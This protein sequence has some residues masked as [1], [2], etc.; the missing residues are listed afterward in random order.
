MKVKWIVTPIVALVIALAMILTFSGQGNALM[1]KMSLNDLTDGADTVVVATVLSTESRW[2]SNN[3]AVYTLVTVEVEENYKGETRGTINVIIPGGTVGDNLEWVSDTPDLKTGDRSVLFLNELTDEQL[4]EKK[5]GI[6]SP[7]YEVFGWYQGKLDIVNDTA[8]GVQLNTL[9]G[10]VGQIASGGSNVSTPKLVS[11]NPKELLL[12]GYNTGGGNKWPASKMPVPYYVAQLPGLDVSRSFT[13]AEITALNN[14][15]S[16]WTNAGANFSML[17]KGTKNS[18]PPKFTDMDWGD[19]PYGQ[20]RNGVNENFWYNM[21]NTVTLGQA[22]FWASGLTE[23][24]PIVECDTAFNSYHTFTTGDSGVVNDMWSVALHEFGH[25]LYLGHTDVAGSVMLPSITQGTT[26]RT[27]GPDDIAGIKALYGSG[28]CT[29][30]GAPSLVAPGAGATVSSTQYTFDWNAASNSPTNYL[31]QIN[32][33]STFTGTS[34]HNNNT[35][36]STSSHL[37]TGLPNN[38]ATLHWRVRGINGCGNGA[39]SAT[40]SF[41]SGSGSTTKPAKP[42]S[43]YPRIPNHTI[44][45]QANSVW[46]RWLGVTGA[47]KYQ[48]Q[49]RQSSSSGT[50]IYDSGT[51]G[52]TFRGL[53]LGGMPNDNTNFY[54]H[55]RGGNASGWGAYSTY[56]RFINGPM[57]ATSPAPT[58]AIEIMQPVNAA[59]IETEGD[60]ATGYLGTLTAASKDIE[61]LAGAVLGKPTVYPWVPAKSNKIQLRWNAVSKA[62]KYWLQVSKY[63]NFSTL[64]VNNNNITTTNRILTTSGTVNADTTNFFYRLKAGNSAGWSAWSEVQRFKN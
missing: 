23:P 43:L 1:L 54:W 5:P 48:I 46:L 63:S 49:V 4:A 12:P 25:W 55:V 8:G 45:S 61:Q 14:A 52:S 27:L 9:K 57:P 56:K 10:L 42:T 47:T 34:Y 26:K 13:A 59:E 62:T 31:L 22:Q 3:S 33:N 51:L 19:G 50:I 32:S 17:Y 35:G 38:G 40:R 60:I 15:A 6:S 58:S 53:I 37:V 11:G 16:T 36:S 2:N 18:R 7:V 24:Y 41:K 30:P 28:G 64:A 39:W 21:G 29:K 20:I 44:N